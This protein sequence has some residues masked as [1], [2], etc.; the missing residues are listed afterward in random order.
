MNIGYMH[1]R[2]HTWIL[3]ICTNMHIHGYWIYA[4]TCTYM[5]IGYINELTH[6]WIW[7]YWIHTQPYTYIDL[8]ILDICTT[9]HIH[10]FVYFGY[11]HKHYSIIE[12]GTF[13]PRKYTSY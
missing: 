9:K 10:G 8:F 1:K 6:T 13:L 5:N 12:E 11:M 7:I 4:Q 3:D 2:K